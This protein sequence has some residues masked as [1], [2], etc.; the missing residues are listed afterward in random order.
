MGGAQHVAVGAVGLF[1]AHLVAKTVSGHEG[2]HFSAAAQFVDEQLIQPRLVDFQ[3]GVGQQTV[4]V[5][6]L[7]V[8]AFEG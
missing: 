6:A 5:E 8:V 4:A 1:G 2:R 7:D 3:A